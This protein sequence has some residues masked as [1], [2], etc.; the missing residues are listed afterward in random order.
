MRFSGPNYSLACRYLVPRAVLFFPVVERFAIDLVNRR[1]GDF[2]FARFSGQ[3]EINVVSLSVR[4][5]HVHAGKIFAATEILQA[6]IVYFYQVESEILTFIFGMEFS[7]F[8]SPRRCF[9]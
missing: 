6:I 2:H 4:P 9:S 3:K 7:V 1:L 8:C 5:F